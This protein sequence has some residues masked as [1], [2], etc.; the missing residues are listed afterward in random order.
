[1]FEEPSGKGLVRD[2]AK[3]AKYKSSLGQAKSLKN[4]SK[5][6]LG[7]TI[8]EGSHSSVVDARAA[9]ALYRIVEKEWE[10]HV[11]QKSYND[12]RKRAEQDVKQIRTM[13]KFL[14]KKTA[15]AGAAPTR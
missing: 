7:K 11:K 15:G 5:E 12:V 14:G 1:M 3:Y 2:V 9:L 6:F 4:L 13:S 8:Q 10:N